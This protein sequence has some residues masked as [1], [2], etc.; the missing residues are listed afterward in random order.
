MT[1]GPIFKAKDGSQWRWNAFRSELRRLAAVSTAEQVGIRAADEPKPS[2]EVERLREALE[3]ALP[4]LRL[5]DDVL[6]RS[7]N[8]TRIWITDDGE[9]HPAKGIGLIRSAIEALSRKQ[10]PGVPTPGAWVEWS[11]GENPVPGRNAEVKLR[12]GD[13]FTGSDLSPDATWQHIWGEADI[14]A[15]RIVPTPG[16]EGE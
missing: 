8:S 1:D 12:S 2:V 16:G 13:C 5:A 7:P 4:A 3:K 9:V 10:E 15:Y 11:G 14:I 6:S